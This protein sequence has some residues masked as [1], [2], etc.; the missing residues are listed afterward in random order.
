[1]KL[2]P[3]PRSSTTSKSS[4]SNNNPEEL[5]IE[6]AEVLYGLMT[7]SQAPLKNDSLSKNELNSNKSGSE[8]KSR[9]SSP[10]SNSSSAAPVTAVGELMFFP[11]QFL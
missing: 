3:Q 5:E 6:I 10:V 7:Q 9:A 4:S 11:G 1:M 8:A 2:R